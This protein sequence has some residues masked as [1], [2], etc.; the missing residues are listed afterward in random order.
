MSINLITDHRSNG[1]VY[2]LVK[3]LLTLVVPAN[4]SGIATA[5]SLNSLIRIV[6]VNVPSLGGETAQLLVL[7]EIGGIIY[8]SG[9]LPE[10]AVATLGTDT[11]YLFPMAGEV[12]VLILLS[13][14]AAEP[15]TISV[16]LYGT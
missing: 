6:T 7:D 14:T 5:L 12:T 16:I 1:A 4:D 2:P 13:G 10:N 3:T 15:K 9:I 11:E 8:E